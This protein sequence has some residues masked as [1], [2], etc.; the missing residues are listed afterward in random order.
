VQAAVNLTEA[1]ARHRAALLAVDSYDIAVDLR[2]AA[3][4]DR[5]TFRTTTEVRFRCTRPGAATF[6]ECAARRIAVASLN[7]AQVD[8][9]GWSAATGLPLV[10]LAG[11]NLLRVTAEFDYAT[12]Q[13]GMFRAVDPADGGIYLYTS[14]EPAAAQRV[15]ACFDQPDLK[16]SFTW[17]ATVPV[18]WRAVSNLPAAATA[19]V[20]D[21]AIT[22]HFAPSPRMS[23][24][25]AVLCAGPFAEVRSG[26]DGPDLGVFCRPSAREQLDAGEIFELIRRGM[27]FYAR[28]FGRPYPLPKLDLVAAPEYRGAMEN[29]GCVVFS[30]RDLIFRSRTTGAERLRRGSVLLHELAHMWFGNLVTLRWWDDLWLNEA[31]ATWASYWCM[32]TV[33]GTGEPWADFAVQHKVRGLKADQEPDAHPVSAPAPDVETA[34]LNFDDIT[35][36]KGASVLKQIAAYVGIDAFTAALRRY[37][38]DHAWGNASFVDLVSALEAESG[39]QLGDFLAGWLQTARPNTLRLEMAPDPGGGYRAVTVVQAA[40]PPESVLRTHRLEIGVYDL[41]DDGLVCRRGVELAV[42]GARTDVAELAGQPRADVLLPDHT[43]LTFARLRLDDASWRT[44][45]RYV[46]AFPNALQRA[47]CWATAGDMLHAAELP[48]RDYLAMVVRCLP[49]ET[50]TALASVVLAEA[51]HALDHFADPDWAAAGWARLAVASQRAADAAEP[52]SVGQL[53][54]VR[55]FCAAARG[56]ADL[57]LVRAWFEGGRLPPGLPVDT[58][59]RWLLLQALVAAGAAGPAE[60][61]QQF[62]VDRS[63]GGRYAVSLTRALVPTPEAKEVAWQAALAPGTSV[64]IRRA[65]LTGFGYP[66]HAPLTAGYVARY[67]D[68][69]APVWAGQGGEAARYVAEYGFPAAHVST[70]TLAAAEA[71]CAAA[72]RPAPLVRVV[73]A[74]AAKMRRALAARSCDAGGYHRSRGLVESHP[75]T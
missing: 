3:D 27:E 49:D 15:F 69:L 58:E 32:D 63:V 72:G 7:G 65:I 2:P 4:L 48:A 39:R 1:Q 40:E 64:T 62:D 30:E 35:Y 17:R 21:R 57:E 18:G 37:F 51:R 47:V 20:G 26:A 75:D 54:W 42:G 33:A 44:V 9:T 5:A 53:L 66:A 52:G 29:F 22:I 67:F 14:F 16:A 73:R 8:L 71:W 23:T 6:V 25:L 59:L 36:R 70:A 38:R 31:F 10:G 34:E 50:D 19:P 28:Q 12:G 46:S 60:V 56:A 55:T 74:A 68:V 41:T 11:T 61:E 13:R 43:D 24:Y 45:T